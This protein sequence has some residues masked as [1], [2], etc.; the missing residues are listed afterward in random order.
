MQGPID[1]QGERGEPDGTCQVCGK[2]G[3]TRCLPDTPVSG[4]F[5]DEHA[6]GFTLKPLSCLIVLILLAVAGWL[7]YTWIFR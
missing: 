2:P 3:W 5:C 4:C 1:M 6:P 7:V